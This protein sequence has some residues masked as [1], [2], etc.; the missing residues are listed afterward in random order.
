MIIKKQIQA[1]YGSETSI[2]SDKIDYWN[3]P[4][5]SYNFFFWYFWDIFIAVLYTDE[6]LEYSIR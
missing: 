3:I 4:S 5:I 1:L 2:K 6:M